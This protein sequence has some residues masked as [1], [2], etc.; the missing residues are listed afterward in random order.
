MLPFG[1]AKAVIGNWPRWK[2]IDVDFRN[3]FPF[4]PTMPLT[5]LA[6]GRAEM[7]RRRTFF[8][9]SYHLTKSENSIQTLLSFPRP[10]IEGSRRRRIFLETLFEISAET[11]FN[12]R[13]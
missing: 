6:A 4:W 3:A 2:S 1:G 13:Y 9:L 11:V 8:K 12:G 5:V 7:D 10:A